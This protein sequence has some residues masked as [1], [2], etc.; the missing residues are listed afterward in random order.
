MKDIVLVTADSVR[1]DY[2]EAMDHVSSHESFQGITG[3]HYT[4][5]SLA[6][7]LSSN[8]Q[9]AIESRATPPTLAEVL[10]HNGYACIGISGSPHTDPVFGFDSGFEYRYTN[11]SDAGQRGSRTRQFFSQFNLIRRLYHRVRPP[12]A[13]L[14]NRPSNRTVVDEAIA[15]FNEAPSPRFLWIHLM[16]THRPYGLGDD[17]VPMSIDRKALFAPSRLTTAEHETILE[18]YR[19]SLSRA[20]REIE[21]LTEHLDGDPIFVFTSDHGDEFGEEGCYFHQPQRRRVAD[22]LITVPVV[23]DGLEIS[24]D[25]FSLLDIAPTLVSAVDI[26]VPEIWDG[27][28]LTTTAPTS[29]VTIAPWHDRAALAWQDLASGV[30]LVARDGNVT[31]DRDGYRVGVGRTEIPEA[32]QT[33][34]R[35]LGYRT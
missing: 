14:E 2:V 12:V 35:D 1:H 6:S 28:D 9:A 17:A 20:D 26:D 16:G 3:S 27:T 29:A 24:A 4:R 8:F 19:Q 31:L 32:I 21:R 34:L 13:K 25:R 23:I 30:K 10:E 33:Q 7:L 11:Y 18:K 22:A 5:P 15:S